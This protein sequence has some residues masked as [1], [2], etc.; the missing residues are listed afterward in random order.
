MNGF[1]TFGFI[2][3]LLGAIGFVAGLQWLGWPSLVVGAIF[4]CYG[5]VLKNRNAC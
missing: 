3:V 5:T 1:Q 4:I 2:V